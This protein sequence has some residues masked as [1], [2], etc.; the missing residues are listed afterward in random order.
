M[1]TTNPSKEK[2]LASEISIPEIV[3]EDLSESIAE[4]KF[5][6]SNMTTENQEF[7]RNMQQFSK[8]LINRGKFIRNLRSTTKKLSYHEISARC[9]SMNDMTFRNLPKLTPKIIN[10]AVEM[11][12]LKEDD[13]KGLIL[14]P[15][16]YSVFFERQELDSPFT[17]NAM[18]NLEFKPELVIFPRFTVICI[19]K[20]QLL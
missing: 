20:I 7:Y 19:I 6:R 13:L 10:Y 3:P 1:K 4:A 17:H 12:I 14:N 2:L 15:N 18:K 16:K 8:E 9:H 11:N 5:L